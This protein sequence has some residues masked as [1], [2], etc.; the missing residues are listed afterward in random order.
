LF[1]RSPWLAEIGQFLCRF[2]SQVLVVTEDKSI[3]YNES[4]TVS[5]RLS[6][7]LKDE[8]IEVWTDSTIVSVQKEEGGLHA[9]LMTKSGEKETVVDKIIYAER[10]AFLDDLGLGAV[11]ISEARPYVQVNSRMET[12]ARGVYATGDLVGD[13]SRYYSRMAAEGGIVAAE[14]A[15][16]Q[17]ASV[18]MKAFTGVLFTDPQVA[19]VGLTPKEA[20]NAGYDVVVGCAPLS[21]NTLGM[22]FSEKEGVVE[23]VTERRFGEALGIHIVGRYASEMAGEAMLA[24]QMETTV[25]ELARISFPHPTLSESLAEA[26][27]DALGRPIYLP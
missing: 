25:E 7:A 12:G 18:N 5:S 8:Q 21:M 20:R 1:G 2:G 22:I 9:K 23:L 11:G 19:C 10:V 24:I 16:G 26:A 27:R 3:L 17:N 15:M 6:K 14:N 4:K 13:I